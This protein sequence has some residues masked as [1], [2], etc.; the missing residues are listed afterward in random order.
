[1]DDSDFRISVTGLKLLNL[2]MSKVR[3]E[4]SGAEITRDV[5]IGPGTLYPLLSR[6][7]QLG[8]LE[9]RWEEVEPSLIGRPR[10]RLYKITEA[11][12]YVAQSSMAKLQFHAMSLNKPFQV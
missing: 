1:M 10:R 12:A 11:G 4:R 9:S 3:A 5:G 7:E 6:F 8:I 2:F